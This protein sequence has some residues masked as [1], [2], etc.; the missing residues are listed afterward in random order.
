MM[1]VNV[2]KVGNMGLGCGPHRDF[3][4]LQLGWFFLASTCCFRLNCVGPAPAGGLCTRWK[5]EPALLCGACLR[6][7]TFCDVSR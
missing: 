3:Q 4:Y 5:C 7:A 1:P 6:V 2:P